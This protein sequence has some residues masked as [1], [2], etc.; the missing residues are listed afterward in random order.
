MTDKGTPNIGLD[1]YELLRLENLNV[2]KLHTFTKAL[3][4]I[5]KANGNFIDILKSENP[6]TPLYFAV[7]DNSLFSKAHLA[8]CLALVVTTKYNGNAFL[9]WKAGPVKLY[10]DV[11]LGACHQNI[12]DMPDTNINNTLDKYLKDLINLS[13]DRVDDIENLHTLQKEINSALEILTNFALKPSS[14]VLHNHEYREARK[15]IG[16]LQYANE[17]INTTPDINKTWFEYRDFVKSN[18]IFSYGYDGNTSLVIEEY[19]RVCLMLYPH[20]TDAKDYAQKIK[21]KYK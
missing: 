7:K 15:Y 14:S 8:V 13:L 4:A 10:E 20:T 11:Y 16:F 17:V 12:G 21:N 9:A 3:E 18:S 19:R 5:N 1:R 6:N 2:L